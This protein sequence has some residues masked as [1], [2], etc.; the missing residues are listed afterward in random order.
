MVFSPRRLL[1]VLR[2]LPDAP[3]YWVAYSGGLDSH[4]LLHAMC[5]LRPALAPAGV[6]AVHV[7]HGLSPHAR[8]WADHCVSVCE[9][10]AVTCRVLAVDATPVRG[11]G[12]EAA[13]R[14]ARYGAIAA[15]MAAGDC[16]LTAHHRGDQGETV[17]LQLL[18]GAGP[19]GL[20]GMPPY[21]PFAAGGHAR[22]LLSF[23]RR[24]LHAYAEDRGLV[25]V[26]DES[27]ANPAL[28][29]NYLRREI[30]PRL[31]AHWPAVDRTLVRVAAHQRDAAALL[32]DIAVQDLAELGEPPHRNLSIEALK[33]LGG[34]RRRNVIRHW[35]RRCR[36]PLPSAEQLRQIEVH[37]FGAA[38][39]R[40]PHVAWPG[41]EVRRYRDRLYA[42]APLPQAP[43]RGVLAWDVCRQAALPCADG[44][45]S[46]HEQVG[47][48][49]KAD[50]CY[51]APV[52]VRFRQGGERCQPAGTDCS[53]TLKNLFQEMGV[54]PWM[55]GRIPL[56]YV[57]DRLA[58]VADY[59]VCHPF[60]AHGQ[61]RGVVFHWQRPAY[62]RGVLV[63]PPPLDKS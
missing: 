39:D 61:E 38:D 7:D 1:T 48:G 60:Q 46:A 13:A 54:P 41:A 51:S 52:T 57:G 9:D 36:L 50:L 62:G 28:E 29:R 24:E 56:V 23:T 20:A 31:R 26:E 3:R 58:A 19:R 32:E 8:A 45:L 33:R 49:V 16:L 37:L 53:R 5:E 27:N 63:D 17:M 18:R 42:S 6:A 11:E 40:M 30:L 12:P 4:V 55:R 14:R 59:W 2:R 15:V 47:A 22:P 35:L 34:A 25:W 10:L 44:V 43:P 21:A